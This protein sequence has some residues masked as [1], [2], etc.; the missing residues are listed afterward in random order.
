[1]TRYSVKNV[2]NALIE[3]E[4]K[5]F[6]IKFPLWWRK[7]M[8]EYIELNIKAYF[9]V[10]H[11]IKIQIKW[12]K[13]NFT[14]PLCVQTMFVGGSG[15]LFTMHVKLIVEPYSKRDFS[16]YICEYVN[17]VYTKYI[18]QCWWCIMHHYS[19]SIVGHTYQ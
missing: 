19:Y 13:F 15:V 7:G 16:S 2:Q 18:L 9:N 10:R 14:S 17:N 12:K 1:M 6:M 4:I 8:Q 5:L 3:M 11:I